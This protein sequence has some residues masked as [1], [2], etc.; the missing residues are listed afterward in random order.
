MSCFVKYAFHF[1][2]HRVFG[3]HIGSSL[4][5]LLLVSY[6]STTLCKRSRKCS[7]GISHRGQ[8]DSKRPRHEFWLHNKTHALA[9]KEAEVRQELSVEFASLKRSAEALEE[10]DEELVAKRAHIERELERSHDKI[11]DLEQSAHKIE[12]T[13]IILSRTLITS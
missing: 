11:E 1:T 4:Q 6:F 12:G 10:Q 7:K 8:C 5:G 9:R 2:L 13:K 3:R